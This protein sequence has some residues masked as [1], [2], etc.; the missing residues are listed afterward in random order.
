MKDATGPVMR[1]NA[2]KK[3]K[4]KKTNQ[5]FGPK[6]DFDRRECRRQHTLPRA[7]DN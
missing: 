5:F 1:E 4:K 2:R 7:R 6:L 3:K